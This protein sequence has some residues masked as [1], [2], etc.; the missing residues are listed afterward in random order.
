MP[1]PEVAGAGGI[2]RFSAPP[3][4]I[5]IFS[6]RNIQ[7]VNMAMLLSS[8]SGVFAQAAVELKGPVSQYAAEV[9]ILTP[10]TLGIWPQGTVLTCKSIPQE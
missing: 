3:T 5:L 8:E 9:L 1:S 4:G 10:V 2:L 7:H 6:L